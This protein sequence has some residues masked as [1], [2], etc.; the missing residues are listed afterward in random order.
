M[1]AIWG[2][3]D[4]PGFSGRSNTT[5]AIEWHVKNSGSKSS[6]SMNVRQVEQDGRVP[7]QNQT[8]KALLPQEEATVVFQILNG[9]PAGE[10][11]F[12]LIPEEGQGEAGVGVLISDPI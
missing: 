9:L 3:D 11:H 6:T 12:Q 10:Y 1:Q 8:L 5:F 4:W 7:D 2:K